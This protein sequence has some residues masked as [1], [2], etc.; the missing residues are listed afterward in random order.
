MRV[1]DLTGQRFERLVVIDRAAN[2]KHGQA[3]WKVLCDCKQE[4]VV[5]GFCLT[6]R[7]VKSC[8]CYKRNHAG[9]HSRTHGQSGYHLIGKKASPSYMSWRAMSQRCLD[10]NA[11]RYPKYGALC[12]SICDRWNPK[13]GGSFENFFEDMGERPKGT[14]L[15]RFGDVGNYE[16]GNVKWMTA[17]EQKANWKSDRNLGACTPKEFPHGSL[18]FKSRSERAA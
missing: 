15:G 13:A 14:T 11:A 8:G 1:I 5:R 2:A 12:V 9:E 7:K 6:S 10:P 17:A 4:R 3:R 16:P 18:S